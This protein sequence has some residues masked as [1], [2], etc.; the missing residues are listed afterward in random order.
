MA[1][2]LLVSTNPA[3]SRSN[4][5]EAYKKKNVKRKYKRQLHEQQLCNKNTR[6]AIRVGTALG[7]PRVT[8]QHRRQ[9][10]GQDRKMVR[11]RV[12]VEGLR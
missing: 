4:A 11:R 9:R 10:G 1:S 8:G 2:T 7:L 12:S 6:R 5:R 3:Q